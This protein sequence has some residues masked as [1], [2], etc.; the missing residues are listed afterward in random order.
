[1][2]LKRYKSAYELPFSFAIVLMVV[3]CNGIYGPCRKAGLHFKKNYLNLL[4]YE[5]RLVKE[6]F[7]WMDKIFVG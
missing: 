2:H 6:V 4:F 7:T 3:L 5:K 1:M